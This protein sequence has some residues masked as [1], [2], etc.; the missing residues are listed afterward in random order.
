MGQKDGF[1]CAKPAAKAQ[2]HPIKKDKSHRLEQC[3]GAPCC[4]RCW[5]SGRPRD[6]GGEEGVVQLEVVAIN[7]PIKKHT[8]L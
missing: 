2:A 4:P 5:I 7:Q 6:P 1:D 8:I 3:P